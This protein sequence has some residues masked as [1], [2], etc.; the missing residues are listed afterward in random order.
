MAYSVGQESG[1]RAELPVQRKF[2]PTVFKLNKDESEKKEIYIYIVYICNL[3]IYI[4]KD[5]CGINI[6]TEVSGQTGT[7]YWV[8][9]KFIKAKTELT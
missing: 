4:Y 5:F 2:L 7:P 6:V 1:C 3:N 8:W 9:Q